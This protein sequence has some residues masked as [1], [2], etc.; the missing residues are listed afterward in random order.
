MKQGGFGDAEE[1]LYRFSGGGSV[2]G[3]PQ[4][5]VCV[6]FCV[7]LG[8]VASVPSLRTTPSAAR[9]GT[10]IWQVIDVRVCH[11]YLFKSLFFFGSVR[12]IVTTPSLMSQYSQF[13]CLIGAKV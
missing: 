11:R 13:G 5:F 6:E 2:G 10:G 8:V 1:N 4:L 3:L 9:L 7:R 12:D